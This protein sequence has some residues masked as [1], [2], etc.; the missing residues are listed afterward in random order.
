MP[1]RSD[2]GHKTESSSAWGA[3]M[4][5]PR[6]L[7]LYAEGVILQSPGSAQPRSGEAPPWVTNGNKSP[8]PKALYRT[9][10]GCSFLWNAFGVRVFRIITQGA[11]LTAAAP[12]RSRPWALEYNAYGVRKSPRCSELGTVREKYALATSTPRLAGQAKATSS[13]RGRLVR[14]KPTA[15]GRATLKGFADTERLG[16]QT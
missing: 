15:S 4:L 16:S 13:G 2:S 5:G 12:R 14:P 8:T 1:I 7:F 10:D 9:F 11:R 6:T 3:W